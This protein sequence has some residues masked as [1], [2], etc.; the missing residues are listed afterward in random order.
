[1]KCLCKKIQTFKSTGLDNIPNQVLKEHGAPQL[2]EWLTFIFQKSVD[3]MSPGGLD[4]HQECPQVAQHLSH[5]APYEICVEGSSSEQVTVDTGV[6][7]GTVL[8][9]LLFLYH[10]NDPPASSNLSFNRKGHLGTTDDF[11]A[12][13]L[14]FSL[15]FTAFW[16]LANSRPVHSLMLSSHLFLCLPCL[17]PPFTVPYKIVFGQT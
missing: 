1:M 14:H 9:P 10:L 4:K 13:F 8:G 12:S 17:L 7:Q 15:F 5:Q 6:P 16:D 2:A 3:R 11:V